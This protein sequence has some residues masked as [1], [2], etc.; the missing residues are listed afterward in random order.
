MSCKCLMAMAAVCLIGFNASFALALADWV[1]FT[2]PTHEISVMLPTPVKASQSASGSAAYKADGGDVT[3]IV[4]FR[5]RSTK[6][7]DSE[8][9]AFCSSFAKGFEAVEAESGRQTKLN[10]ASEVSGK[11]WKGR[12]YR[13]IKQTGDPGAFEIAISDRHNFVLHVVGGTDIDPNTKRFFTSFEV[14]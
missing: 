9:E 8:I 13:Y 14:N 3:Y 1:K 7:Q 10:L 5:R 2:D 4:N 6:D 11:H 12:V